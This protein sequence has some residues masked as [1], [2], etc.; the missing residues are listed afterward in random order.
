MVIPP[1][2]SLGAFVVVLVVSG[3]GGFLVTR[4]PTFVSL[5]VYERE[6]RRYLISPSGELVNDGDN[7]F[8]ALYSRVDEE[9]EVW[10]VGGYVKVT[11]NSRSFASA[12]I[13]E[14]FSS[15]PNRR[16]YRFVKHH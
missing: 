16:V 6:S 10:N 3:G 15:L 8:K 13:H 5:L 4:L 14:L 1:F 2:I 7:I 12:I 11:V 9:K